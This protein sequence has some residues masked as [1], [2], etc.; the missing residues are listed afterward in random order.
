MIDILKDTSLIHSDVDAAAKL[1]ADAFHDNPG[2]TYIYPDSRKRY[3]Q[4][5]WLMRTNLN[6]Q[7]VVGQSFAK[8]DANG[9]I[10]AMGFWHPPGAPQASKLLLFRFGFFSMPFR[11]GM[12]AFKRML[13][14]VEQIE[15]KRKQTLSGR[16]NWYLNNMVVA[17]DRRGQG[18]GSDILRKEL[19]TIISVSGHP[20]SL[21]TQKLE[22]VSFYQAL[23]FCVVNDDTIGDNKHGFQNWIM[24]L[25]P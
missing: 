5:L 8:K 18:I 17:P 23:G 25:E 13:S 10:V 22:N 20:V 19:E 6:A 1:L 7:L 21:T 2:H 14:M 11:H 24:I 15:S 4:L 9:K 12:P 16:E 3:G